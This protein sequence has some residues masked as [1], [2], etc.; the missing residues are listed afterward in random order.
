MPEASARTARRWGNRKSLA[1]SRTGSRERS[2]EYRWLVSASLPWTCEVFYEA[3]RGDVVELR[4][5][6]AEHWQ[7]FY[8]NFDAAKSAFCRHGTGMHGAGNNR[9]GSWGPAVILH[10]SV[11]TPNLF[12]ASLA[13][14]EAAMKDVIEALAG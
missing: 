12:R 10:T 8:A 11:L 2:G 1:V 4:L 7:A 9:G 3:M 13:R 14:L 6:T 5:T